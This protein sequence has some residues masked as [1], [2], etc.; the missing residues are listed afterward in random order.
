MLSR[1][2]FLFT[3]LAPF[4]VCLSSFFREKM[5]GGRGVPHLLLWAVL[6]ASQLPASLVL[7]GLEAAGSTSR[8]APAAAARDWEWARLSLSAARRSTSRR[9][10]TQG[11]CITST[12]EVMV[13]RGVR[14]GGDASR[15]DCPGCTQLVRVPSCAVDAPRCMLV[16]G[17]PYVDDLALRRAGCKTRGQQARCK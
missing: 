14:G 11:H 15:V 6:L 2:F 12:N 13:L 7:G 3:Q 17:V 4:L 16:S 10:P 1:S 9:V 5:A 8:G